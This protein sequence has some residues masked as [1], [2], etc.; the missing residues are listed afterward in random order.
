MPGA[1]LSGLVYSFARANSGPASQPDKVRLGRITLALCFSMAKRRN[2]KSIV[3]ALLNLA[4]DH[5]IEV[6]RIEVVDGEGNKVAIVTD[7]DESGKGTE[8]D[9]W[10]AGK[11]AH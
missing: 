6:S 1:A 5:D 8:L 3:K 4:R 9:K 7:K 10:L 11:H 2:T